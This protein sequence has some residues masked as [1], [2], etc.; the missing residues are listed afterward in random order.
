MQLFK[1][2]EGLF[3]SA[4][5][6][7]VPLNDRFSAEKVALM[8][9]DTSA[10]C[11]RLIGINHANRKLDQPRGSGKLASLGWNRVAF[12]F[13][14]AL[15]IV[16]S[17]DERQACSNASS[18]AQWLESSS[19]VFT[20][21]QEIGRWRDKYSLPNLSALS[22]ND[23]MQVDSEAS[24][25]NPSNLV[26][27]LRLP[28]YHFY[29]GALRKILRKIFTEVPEKPTKWYIPN[30]NRTHTLTIA[31]LELFLLLV[32]DITENNLDGSRTLGLA[33][34]ITVAPT[35]MQQRFW[36]HCL[37]LYAKRSD[38]IQ[39]VCQPLSDAEFA[40][41]GREIRGIAKISKS[42]HLTHLRIATTYY[43]AVSVHG[44]SYEHETFGLLRNACKLVDEYAPGEMFLF[45]ENSTVE[46]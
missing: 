1:S 30:G 28:K 43:Q 9:C 2:L 41:C 20:R 42:F 8:A 5:V 12:S 46:R 21:L 6:K 14:L 40:M 29:S 37:N 19:T 25:R 39:H 31:D 32:H 38:N 4:Q 44:L 35:A 45:D 24:S 27:M 16:K 3:L 18:E 34:S 26:L 36:N 15:A 10:S 7:S 11:K 33:E 17:R 23:I 13:H 22:Y